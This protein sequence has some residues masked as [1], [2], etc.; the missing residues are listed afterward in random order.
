[1]AGEALSTAANTMGLQDFRAQNAIQPNQPVPLNGTGISPYLPSHNVNPANDPSKMSPAFMALYNKNHPNGN[2]PPSP[3]SNGR[4][5]FPDVDPVASIRFQRDQ[6]TNTIPLNNSMLSKEP[7]N[8]GI[9]GEQSIPYNPQYQNAINGLV[10][11]AQGETGK[12]QSMLGDMLQA[13]IN[14]T[15]SGYSNPLGAIAAGRQM[16]ALAGGVAHANTEQAENANKAMS[17][18]QNAI[19]QGNKMRE[20]AQGANIKDVSTLR[21]ALQNPMFPAQKA[22]MEAAAAL[23]GQKGNALENN[24]QN[25]KGQLSKEIENNEKNPD[26]S[27]KPGGLLRA[28]TAM[29]KLARGSSRDIN[30]SS[31]GMQGINKEDLK[32]MQTNPQY[33][34]IAQQQALMRG[35]TEQA[36]IYG[37]FANIGALPN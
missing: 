26:G 23:M 19:T 4:T 7:N 31:G 3:P 12:T 14:T 5:P 8:P 30:A 11:R 18:L 29:E 25:V 27:W 2:A 34:K 1:M 16:E 10:N 20:E 35:D 22:H 6:G 33:A 9:P 21:Q 15:P 17:P 28:H 32:L 37:S 13:R 24:F 36:A